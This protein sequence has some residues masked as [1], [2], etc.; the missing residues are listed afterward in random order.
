MNPKITVVVPTFNRS[1]LLHR[2]LTALD[3]QSISAD[4]FEV[5]VVDD[6]SND[7]TAELLKAQASCSRFPL[8]W[9]QQPHAGPSAARNEGLR[10]ARGDW[11]ALT[12]DDCIPDRNWLAALTAAMP[13]DRQYA[14]IGG[15]VRRVRDNCI[16]RYI[17]HV[18]LMSSWVENGVVEY[19]IT[20]NA[21]FRVDTLREIG[22]FNTDL[23]RTIRANFTLGGGEDVDLGYRLRHAGYRLLLTDDGV[24]YHHHHDSIREFYKM[25]WRHGYGAGSVFQPSQEGSRLP[26]RAA[27]LKQLVRALKTPTTLDGNG[28]R[29]TFAWRALDSI[30]SVAKFNGRRTCL[31]DLQHG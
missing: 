4:I 15:S 11:I 21:F 6:G 2:C 24:V 17:D 7:G 9:Y 28:I 23:G 10:R 3:G 22:G 27:L 1:E 19:L 14:G 29:E 26:G 5:V 31:R 13:A 12:D 30:Q 16:G 18:G 8:I 20:A 25:C